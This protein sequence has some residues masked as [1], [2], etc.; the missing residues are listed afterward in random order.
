MAPW[1]DAAGLTGWQ[2]NASVPVAVGDPLECDV[3]W[4]PRQVILEVS[5]FHTHGSRAA[6]ERDAE[7]RGLLVAAGWRIIEATDDDLVDEAAF[8][9]VVGLLRAVMVCPAG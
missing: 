7:R 5:P 4:W 8:Q 6:Q 3:V 2:A 1:L 9:R